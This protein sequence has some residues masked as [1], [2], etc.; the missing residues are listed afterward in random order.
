MFGLAVLRIL[1]ETADTSA[2][3]A[4]TKVPTREAVGLWDLKLIELEAP[5]G[6]LRPSSRFSGE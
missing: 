3:A 6:H 2:P 1:P 4:G 5:H